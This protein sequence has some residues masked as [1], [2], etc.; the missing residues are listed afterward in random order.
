MK[1][2]DS[3]FSITIYVDASNSRIVTKDYQVSDYKAL[4]DKLDYIC[5]KNKL[6]KL[7]FK[8]KA[9]DWIP[10]L[11]Y[12]FILEGV[13]K[14]FFNG[15]DAYSL[16]KYYSSE[17]RYSKLTEQEDEIIK[18]IIEKGASEIDTDLEADYKL[19]KADKN[20][21]EQLVKLYDQVFETYPTPITDKNYVSEAMDDNVL[22]MIIEHDGKIISA[23]SADIDKNNKNAEMTDCATNPA[24]R[25]KGLMS[26]LIC[27]LEQEMLKNNINC[28]YTIARAK[29]FGMNAVFFKHGYTYTGRL[30]N[31]CDISGQ[32]ED[33]N[34]WTK[35]LSKELIEN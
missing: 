30:I 3:G 34:I 26:A 19:R 9:P 28:L 29:S 32:F 5:K 2:T 31:N 4:V 22:F 14:N 21:I 11:S 25:G 35:S 13:I 24:Y 23:A 33:M 16:A 8:A 15:Q 27:A 7:F 17:R 1:L 6:T 12:G 20:D 10:L 18:G